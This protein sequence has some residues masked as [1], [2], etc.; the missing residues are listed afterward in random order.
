MF[1]RVF[2][3]F[4]LMCKPYWNFLKLL[5]TIQWNAQVVHKHDI[6]K[7]DWRIAR[8]IHILFLQ[9]FVSRL[10]WCLLVMHACH[11]ISFKNTSLCCVCGVSDYGYVRQNKS[12]IKYPQK[13]CCLI[14][15]CSIFGMRVH[16]E[17]ECIMRRHIM[18]SGPLRSWISFT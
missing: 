17:L 9:S 5:K 11:K 16:C 1:V 10:C 14:G 3:H 12:I 7:Q 18:H 8:V 4:I 6:G 15:Q 2:M 13:T